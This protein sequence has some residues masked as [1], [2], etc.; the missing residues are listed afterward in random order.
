MEGRKGRRVRLLG[1]ASLAGALAMLA[2]CQGLPVREARD[3]APNLP[4]LEEAARPSPPTPAPAPRAAPKPPVARPA[5]PVPLKRFDI[6]VRDVPA[7]EFFLGLAQG[8]PWNIV[9]HPDVKGSITL[10]L[11]QVT[12]QEVL[13]VVQDVYGYGVRRTGNIWR[14]F[15]ATEQTRMFRVD[16]LDLQRSGTSR[17]RVSS[18]Q[19]SEQVSAAS[20]DENASE[21]DTEDGS[22]SGEV[23]RTAVSGSEVETDSRNDFWGVLERTLRLLVG[24]A[25]GRRVMVN[26]QAGLVIVRATPDRLHEVGRYLRA[27][28]GNVERQVILEAR[29][30]EVELNDR[31][32]TGINWAALGEP[33][34]GKRIQAGM[35]GGGSVFDNGVTSQQGAALTL[36]GSALASGVATTRFG[37]VFTL[38]L[39]LNDFNALI[40]LLKTQGKVQ[41]LS[42][43]RIATVNNQKAVIKVGTDEFFVTDV[44]T[45]TSITSVSALN[46]A[47]NV[48]LT[49]FFSGV[50][51]DVVPQIDE[52]GDVIL[53]I[54]P[55]VSEV[56]EKVKEINVS[57]DTTLSVPLALSSIRETDTIIRARSGQVVVIGGLMKDLRRDE[58]AGLTGFSELP[59][60]GG[61]FRHQRRQATKSELIILLRPIVVDDWSRPVEAVAERLQE[62][63]ARTLPGGE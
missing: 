25:E 48:E 59:L 56:T 10:D 26:P 57:T 32:Q 55:T 8:T 35:A 58:T 53:H 11:K 44:D 9:V 38:D 63:D 46:Q 62:F 61:L 14:I 2:G 36:P 49:P 33:G 19:I 5:A 23:T 16:Y 28:Q 15:P 7:R 40:E 22:E 6:A 52:D 29:I 13:E 17:T 41:V 20:N 34:N 47:V 43:P 54:H 37:G 27:L 42:S 45:Q 1:A 39:A 12:L 21:T 31:F 50:A 18:G 4:A 3:L 60:F 24:D 51:L 30:I